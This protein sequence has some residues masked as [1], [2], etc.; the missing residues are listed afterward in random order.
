MGMGTASFSMHHAEFLCG[1]RILFACPDQ[2]A[3][4][5]APS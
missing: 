3:G 2:P 1:Y 4:L 5:A